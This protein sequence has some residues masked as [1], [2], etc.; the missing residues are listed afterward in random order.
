M[1]INR[2]FLFVVIPIILGIL[3]FAYGG[4]AGLSTVQLIGWG[5]YPMVLGW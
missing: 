1:R 5:S 4:S 3:G 2:L